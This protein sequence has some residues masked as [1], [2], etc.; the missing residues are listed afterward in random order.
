MPKTLRA[1]V[2]LK[3]R[4]GIP[5]DSVQ[6]VWHFSIAD[7]VNR[8]IAAD[9][10]AGYLV[11]FYDAI[12]GY[13]SRTLKNNVGA[14]EIKWYEVNVGGFGE[15]DDFS[16]S[17]FLLNTF[18]TP[19][20][21]YGTQNFPSEIA[22]CLSVEADLSGSFEEFGATRPNARRRGRLYIGPLNINTASE[23]PG[24]QRARVSNTFQTLLLDA[25]N[26][27]W[28]AVETM[29]GTDWVV[30]SRAEG[31]TYR[32]IKGWVD[33]AFDVQRRRG[34]KA[35]TRAEYVFTP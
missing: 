3:K 12:D 4:S 34:E 5:A 8:A 13:L 24:T 18:T 20:I 11:D 21:D 19:N 33:D 9:E 27:L 15:G 26:T 6:N 10:L 16:G 2:D 25:A 1:V 17:P 35:V 23:E 32:I 7:A 22:A 28:G 30:Y 29:V 14:H 31:A